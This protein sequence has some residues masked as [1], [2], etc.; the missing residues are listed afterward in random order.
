MAIN[1]YP[2]DVVDIVSKVMRG[3]GMAWFTGKHNLNLVGIRGDSKAAG[4]FDDRFLAC[5]DGDDGPIVWFF[6]GTTDPGKHWLL[7]PMRTAGCAVLQPGQ[8][9]GM[10]E[11][12]LHKG[13]PALVQVKP[14]RIRRDADKDLV[15]DP[16][17]AFET[18]LFMINFHDPGR[19][20]DRAVVDWASAGCQVPIH[21]RYVT[22]VR[23]MLW[24]QECAGL[25]RSASYSLLQVVDHAELLPL[26][27]F[28][29]EPLNV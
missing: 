15:I 19:E 24:A 14:A 4:A 6:R 28:D 7:E 12:G 3:C 23:G 10:Y 25:G 16:E 2:V 22:M 8:Y 1:R 17:G 21:V 13:R 27:S 9:R 26:F 11:C 18:G 29:P 5:C 20:G